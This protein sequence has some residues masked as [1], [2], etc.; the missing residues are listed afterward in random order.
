MLGARPYAAPIPYS[1]AEMAR[2]SSAWLHKQYKKPSVIGFQEDPKPH[3]TPALFDVRVQGF[4]CVCGI[5][6]HYTGDFNWRTWKMTWELG[7]YEDLREG[8][9]DQAESFGFRA[10]FPSREHRLQALHP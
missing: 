4:G 9:L 3:A 1:F 7:E 8:F 10:W 2:Y 5:L 6:S